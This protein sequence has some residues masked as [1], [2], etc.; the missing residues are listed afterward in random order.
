M[1]ELALKLLVGPAVIVDDEIFAEGAAIQDLVRELKEASFPVIERH[2]IPSSEEI[3]HWQGMSVIILDWDLLGL[4]ESGIGVAVPSNVR[5]NPA[6]DPLRFVNTLMTHLYC[7]IY[8]ISNLDTDSIWDQIETDRS[9]QMCRQLRAR[10]MVRQKNL[11]V[12][13]LLS[14]LGSWISEHA[15]IYVLKTWEREYE[16]AKRALFGDFQGS[17]VEWPRILWQTCEDDNVNA[18]HFLTD[19]ITRNLTHMMD[20]TSFSAELLAPKEN[21]DS[22][23]SVRRVLHQHAVVPVQRLHDNVI[24]PGDFF[25][26]PSK[27]RTLP[28]SIEICL[29]PACDLVDRDGNEDELSLLL[30]RA[31]RVPDSRFKSKAK[32]EKLMDTEYSTQTALLHHLVPEDAMY[33]VS[34]GD[35]R[36]ASWGEMKMTR[37]GRLLEPY[38][39]LLLQRNALYFQRQGLP[40]LPRDFYL[41]R[42]TQ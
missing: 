22:M 25:F 36:M 32:I 12:G 6:V 24:M 37:Q 9:H 34:F 4:G 39:T 42:T 7:P 16:S 13:N 31:I 5:R 11:L 23:D 19:T 38:V 14:E 17:D 35:W 33:E 3:N 26:Q 27:D 28:E 20:L 41:P 1:R 29:T 30:V 8:V 10:I 21:I 40:R 2:E 15:A 18:D